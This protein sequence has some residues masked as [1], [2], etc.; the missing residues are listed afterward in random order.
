MVRIS[1]TRSCFRWPL[2]L[3]FLGTSLVAATDYETTLK[4]LFRERCFSCHGALQQKAGLRLD[5]IESMRKG[6]KHGPVLEPGQPASSLLLQRVSATDPDDRMPPEHEGQPFS[7]AQTATLRDWIAAGAPAPADEVA[8]VDPREHWAFRSRARPAVPS[9][10]DRSWGRNPIDAF[11]AQR[12]DQQEITPQPEAPRATLIRRLY[13]DLIGLPPSLAELESLTHHPAADWYE[14]LV[15]R[16]LDDPRHG[17]RWARHWMDI[18]RYSD[19]WGLGEQHRNSQKHLWHWRDWIIESLNRNLPYDEMIRLML[20]ADETHPTDLD[21]LRATGFLARNYFLF[22]RNQWMDETVEHVGK[23]LLGVTLNCAKCHDHKYD[24]FTH[25]DYYRFRAFFEPYHARLDLL[26]G[27]PDLDRDGLPRAYDRVL[28][29]PTYRFVRGQETAPD[30]SVSLSPGVPGLLAFAGLKVEPVALPLEAWQ[31]ERRPWVQE[32]YLNEARSHLETARAQSARTQ[33]RL[34]Q[35]RET[36]DESKAEW[37]LAER[38]LAVAEAEMAAVEKRA[39]AVRARWSGSTDDPVPHR[40]AVTA[41]RDLAATRA[42]RTVAQMELRLLQAAADRKDTVGK[43][44]TTAREHLAKAL[45]AAAAPPKA[46]DSY[47]PL[48]GARWTATRFFDS[49]KDDPAVDFLST[50]TGRRSALARWIADPRNPLTARVAVNHL[51]TRHFGAPLVATVFDFGR[52]GG[53]PTHPELIDWLACELV[54]SGWDLKHLHRLIVGSATYR[55]GSTLTGAEA[56]MAKDPDNRTWWRRPSI[57]LEAEVVRDSILAQAGGLD[58]VIGGPPVTGPEQADSRRR[59]LYFYHSNNDRNLFLTTF[60]EALVKECYRREQSIV[61]QQALALLNSGLVAGA[62]PRIA[63]RL[64]RGM[65]P[66]DDEAF[67]RAAFNVLLGFEPG[68]TE[69]NESL[70][71]LANWR[72]SDTKGSP[73]TAHGHARTYLVW[74]LI[75]HGDFVTLR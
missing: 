30:K 33:A 50:S 57:R 41:E 39:E 17:E 75:N 65:K 34:V 51:W 26:P 54:D 36:S 46:G 21:R 25:A 55:M 24:P 13:L 9:V 37:N 40:S 49:T 32:A 69:L 62:A 10:S 22:N 70:Q 14:R 56:A 15:S 3:A 52:K 11:I 58:S 8:E 16:L 6:G 45:E 71:A 7:A 74:A 73:P 59:S 53:T 47:A 12:Q 5:T 43:E 68:T 2:L 18:W 72:G 38:E 44:L 63:D 29:P 60:D 19:P 20:S 35:S 23:S 42:K 1:I 64:S 66:T 48:P 67:V 61:P 4:P 27:Q 28:D 31:P